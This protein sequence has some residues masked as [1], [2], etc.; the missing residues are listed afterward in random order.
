MKLV[1]G[2]HD[3]QPVGNFGWVIEEIYE[4]SYAPFLDVA[5]QHPDFRFCLHV[6]GPLFEWMDEFRPE[7]LDR[8]RTMVEAGRVEILGGAFYEPI[9]AA[10]PESD[11]IGQIRMMQQRMQERLGAKPRGLWLAERVWEP[12]LAGSLARAGVEFALLDDFHFVQAGIAP[13]RLESGALRTDDL[14]AEVALLPI[15]ERLRY[16]I[17][18]QDPSKTVELCREVHERDPNGVLIMVDDGEKFGAWPGTS[19][20]VY[21]QGWLDRFMSALTAESDWLELSHPSEV[22][23][24]RPP[25]ERVYLPPNSYFEMSEWSLPM[26]AAQHYENLVE[27][28]RRDNTWEAKRPFMRGGFWRQFFQ[29]YEESL[30]MQRRALLLHD[31]IAL[32]AEAG[33]DSERLAEARDHLWRAECNCAYW[34]GVF[35]GLTLPHLRHAIWRHLIL[36]TQIVQT[37]F[38]VPPV[39]WVTLVGARGTD[40]RLSNPAHEVFLSPERGGAIVSFEDRAEDW[41]LLNTL[42]RRREAY[43]AKIEAA[44]LPGEAGEA[45]EGSSIHDIQW[46]V[47]PEVKAALAVDPQHRYALRDRL[48]HSDVAFEDVHQDMAAADGGDLVEQTAKVNAGQ[49]DEVVLTLAGR[50]TARDGYEIPVTLTK[51]IR[52]TVDGLVVRRTLRNDGPTSLTCRFGCEWNVA[53]YDGEV[54]LEGGDGALDASDLPPSN[55]VAVRVPLHQARLTWEHDKPV[56]TWVHPVRTATQGEDGFHLT[57]QGHMMLFSHD[58]NLAP[59]EETTLT[60]TVTLAHG[61]HE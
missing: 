34:H 52:L 30:L 41:N 10:I 50:Y 9:L 18:F 57:Y 2:V 39:S 19:E 31:D 60:Q 53:L 29:K 47:T 49:G 11:R 55:R 43:H 33:A 21:G 58:I 25:R 22:L 40:L 8:V 1:F 44:P 36:G 5:E 35:G 45:A 4:K 13:E 54:F 14:G 12:H 42:R 32:A 56:T 48:L 28:Y 16:L 26:P 51:G 46:E 38:P 23:D 37:V 3:H 15:D 27:E 61:V 20:S 7:W 6:T 17:P 24:A 59:G